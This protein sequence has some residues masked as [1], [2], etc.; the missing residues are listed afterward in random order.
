[1]MLTLGLL[2][3]FDEEDLDRAIRYSEKTRVSAQAAGQ[4]FLLGVNTRDLRTLEVDRERL[5]KYAPRMPEAVTCVAESGLVTAADAA[6]VAALGYGAALVG[7]ALMRAENPGRLI[8]EMLQA[9]RG[10]V[11]G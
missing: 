2:E 11:D 1:M 7:T 3:A 10:E 6:G 8:G 9:G 4:K 5:Q